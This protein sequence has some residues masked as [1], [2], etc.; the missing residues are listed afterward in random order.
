MLADVKTDPYESSCV[1]LFRIGAGRVVV[2]YRKYTVH[3]RA[4]MRTAH[5]LPPG[6]RGRGRPGAFPVGG[7]GVSG[8]SLDSEYV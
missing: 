3:G 6:A 4:H 2:V 5:G 8:Y 1:V 7:R